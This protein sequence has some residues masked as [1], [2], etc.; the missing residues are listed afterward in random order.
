MIDDGYQPPQRTNPARDLY[1]MW[2]ALVQYN[3]PHLLRPF[4]DGYRVNPAAFTF[5]SEHSLHVDRAAFQEGVKP[6]LY[7]PGVMKVWPNGHFSP[8]GGAYGSHRWS[9]TILDIYEALT[10]LRWGYVNREKA[11]WVQD[12]PRQGGSAPNRQY[13]AVSQWEKRVP[14]LPLRTGNVFERA[15]VYRLKFTTAKFTTAWVIVACGVDDKSGS[16]DQ[17]FSPAARRALVKNA[18]AKLDQRYGIANRRYDWWKRRAELT[19]IREGRAEKPSRRTNI[20]ALDR[21]NLTELIMQGV[22]VYEPKLG[23]GGK[24]LPQQ[25]ALL[26]PMEVTHG[27]NDMESRALVG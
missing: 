13:P 14:Y 20:P 15:A 17:R 16:V 12:T 10:F 5:K 23:P 25:M 27:R 19:A 1:K 3:A 18:Q 4:S 9:G 8:L 11:L 7:I 26:T 22:T 6:P 2:Y 24:P 21:V